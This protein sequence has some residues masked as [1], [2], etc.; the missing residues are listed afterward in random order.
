MNLYKVVGEAVVMVAA[1]SL[2]EAEAMAEQALVE[3]M[4]DCGNW[5]YLVTT[6]VFNVHEVPVDWLEAY[7]RTEDESANATCLQVLEGKHD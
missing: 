2:E 5:D 3:E 4:D 7:P 6:P 1:P